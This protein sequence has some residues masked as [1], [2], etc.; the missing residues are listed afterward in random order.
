[1]SQDRLPD[2]PIDPAFWVGSDE[3]AEQADLIR[4]RRDELEERRLELALDAHFPIN[5][6]L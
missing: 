3:W 5:R 4:R 2:L 6:I 1:M